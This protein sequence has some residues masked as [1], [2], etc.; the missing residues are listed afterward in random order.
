MRTL[1]L[2]LLWLAP[3]SVYADK[4]VS[5]NQ[6]DGLA[7]VLFTASEAK[8]KPAGT[9]VKIHTDGGFVI[10]GKVVSQGKWFHKVMAKV[11][12]TKIEKLS[13]QRF[14]VCISMY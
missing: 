12:V 11:R 9:R 6:H 2:L 8:S 1:L 14:R 3:T 7:Y 13:G 10:E 5:L 4:L